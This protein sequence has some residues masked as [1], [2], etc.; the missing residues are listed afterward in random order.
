MNGAQEKAE[1]LHSGQEADGGVWGK[2]NSTLLPSLHHTR[3]YVP[4]TQQVAK[5][6]SFDNYIEQGYVR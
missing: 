2:V 6:S 5:P 1:P 4:K 3:P